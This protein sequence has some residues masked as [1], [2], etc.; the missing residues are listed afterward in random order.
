MSSK[1]KESVIGLYV[2]ELEEKMPK[3]FQKN[4]LKPEL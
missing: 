2:C 4:E 1:H 3:Q